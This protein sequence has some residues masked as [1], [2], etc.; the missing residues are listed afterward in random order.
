[1]KFIFLKNN[2]FDKSIAITNASSTIN[3][4]QFDYFLVRG[5]RDLPNG[6][7]K[8]RIAGYDERD[9][10]IATLVFYNECFYHNNSFS[11]NSF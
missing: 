1:M 7:T 11:G 2:F 8:A 3:K 4:E 5:V 10:N 6:V 9:G